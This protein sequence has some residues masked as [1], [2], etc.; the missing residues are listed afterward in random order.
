MA[1]NR[2]KYRKNRIEVRK[3]WPDS[4]EFRRFY[5]NMSLARRSLVRI[6]TA[7]I[8]GSCRTL[9][10]ELKGKFKQE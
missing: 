6:E 5:P 9:R 1:I 10:E 2:V 7:I 4:S 3:R 8:D